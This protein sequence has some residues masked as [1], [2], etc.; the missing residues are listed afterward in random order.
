VPYPTPTDAECTFYR[1]HGWVRVRDAIPPA[2]IADL[3]KRTRRIIEAPAD[4]AYDPSTLASEAT[5]QRPDPVL[6]S[7]LQMVWIE[8]RQAAFH[9]WTARFAAALAGR[10]LEFWY[11][12]LMFKPPLVGAPTHWHQD[13]ALLLKSAPEDL[14]ISCWLALEDAT[15]EGGCM[16]FFDRGHREGIIDALRPTTGGDYGPAS[17]D[18]DPSR[19]VACPLEVGDVTF[20]HGK[21]PHR[22]GPNRSQGWRR[23][24]IQRFTPK[25]VPI[26]VGH[27]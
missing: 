8:W 18:V 9:E 12:Q 1:E 19:V 21:T 2:A 26:P 4:L 16:H 27:G 7:C 22:A 17:W 11:D 13:E 10:E 6:V 23:A 5:G 25:G 24:L 20:H 14:L 15:V 3:A